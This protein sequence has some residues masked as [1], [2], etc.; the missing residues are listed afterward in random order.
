MEIS[1]QEVV[2]MLRNAG[3]REE[4]E[5]ALRVLSDPVDLDHA[6]AWG[7]EHGITRNELISRL[8]GSS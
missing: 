1:R 5:E 3:F 4:A 6:A 8:G 2:D 7:Q